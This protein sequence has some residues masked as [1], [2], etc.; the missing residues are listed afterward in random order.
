M[1]QL[2]RVA[3]GVVIL[4]SVVASTASAQV[5]SR[6]CQTC[7]SSYYNGIY[8]HYFSNGFRGNFYACYQGADCHMNVVT[9]KCYQHHWGQPRCYLTYEF[10][11]ITPWVGPALTAVLGF[12]TL[13][14]ASIP[15]SDRLADQGAAS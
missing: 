15:T 3:F 5:G 10:P 1:K 7:Q 4:S 9:L 6:S 12:P 14:C 8:V 2:L 11:R 13:A